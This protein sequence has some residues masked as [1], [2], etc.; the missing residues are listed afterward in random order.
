M[1]KVAAEVEQ[2]RAAINDSHEDRARRFY[3]LQLSF[4]DVDGT[5]STWYTSDGFG[6]KF[7]PRVELRW[8]N[9]GRGDGPERQ[10]GGRSISAPLFRVCEACGHVD[11]EA[12]SNSI[13][14]HRPW[15]PLRHADQE[16]TVS[17]ALGRTL[18]TQG[19]LLY[20]PERL[21]TH[22][23][24]L[25][26]PSLIAAIRMGFREVLGGNPDHLEVNSVRVMG[27]H[28]PMDA[29]L[30]SDSVPGGT[31]YLQQFMKPED[32]FK[33][34]KSALA[35]VES[36][37]CQTDDRL[38]CPDCLL[39]FSG[40]RTDS[41]S[42]ESAEVTLRSILLEKRNPEPGEPVTTSNW[43]TVTTERPAV[44]DGSELELR[45]RQMLLAQLESLPN[46]T[47]KQTMSGGYNLWTFE[48]PGGARWQMREQFSFGYTIPD[49]YFE[50]LNRDVRPIA[51]F[52]DGASFHASAKH[53]R[54][55]SDIS[56]RRRLYDD[57][58][59]PFS[60]TSHDL[61]RFQ[62]NDLP[63]PRWQGGVKGAKFLQQLGMLSATE[64][65]LLTS[66]PLTLFL[67]VLDKPESPV[68]NEMRH[69]AS[70]LVMSQSSPEKEGEFLVVNS[71]AN[72]LRVRVTI[73]GGQPRSR[74]VLFETVPD[75]PPDQETWNDFL[76]L[77]NLFW[78]SDEAVEVHTRATFDTSHAT[79]S[80]VESYTA[81]VAD[82]WA[83]IFEEL[84]G[85]GVDNAL[86]LLR[87]SRSV[88]AD[89]IG[90]ELRG[91]PAVLIWPQLKIAMLYDQQTEEE[92]AAAELR[93]DGWTLFAA[94]GLQVEGIPS[95]LLKEG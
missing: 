88:L 33:L 3:N 23:D 1:K 72:L 92:A 77:A 59:L 53:N 19:V 18:R 32:V 4:D 85:D 95:A 63:S 30:L 10:L 74:H 82:E 37:A 26:V 64:R 78:L 35:V 15:C 28:G 11:S 46:V 79:S 5:G 70:A 27:N 80:P 75:A 50:P 83:G 14:D 6:A 24:K 57:D 25:A 2:T 44:A 60:I 69:A 41:I 51:V 21:S 93:N 49:F 8:L 38:S 7:M 13:W 91:L 56:S 40:R 29:L 58:I 73:D 39:P 84:D 81:D 17:F 62:D 34:L 31:G 67:A 86:A 87:D 76:N 68:W 61:D 43:E 55:N 89:E 90:E 16:E 36:C 66:S 12:G 42:R 52:L 48:M 45:F 54:V 9:L 22:V 20:L 47:V 71:H 65:E 94:A